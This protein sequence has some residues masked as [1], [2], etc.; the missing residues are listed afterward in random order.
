[1]AGVFEDLI[2]A[3][4]HFALYKTA[5]RLGGEGAPACVTAR[6][7]VEDHVFLAIDQVGK[8]E[9]GAFRSTEQAPVLASLHAPD[10]KHVALFGGDAVQDLGSNPGG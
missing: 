2:Q 8:M 1:M 7:K 10:V 5:A 9:G 6:A 4:L 3:A